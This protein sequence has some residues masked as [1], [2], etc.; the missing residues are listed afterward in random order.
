MSVHV[1]MVAEKPILAE[2]IA[3]IL[4]GGSCETRKGSNGACSIS[5][6]KGRFNNLSA[7]FKVTS[8]CGHVMGV[9]FPGKFNAW[10]RTD[11]AELFT[12]PIEHIEANPKLRMPA[13]LASVA[14]GCDYLVLWLDCDKEGENICFEV[15]DA[16]Q[17]SMKPSRSNNFLNVV[18]RARFSA[19]TEKEI[20]DAMRN[21]VRPNLNESLSVDARQELD[22]R[23]GCA[24]TRFQTKFFQEKYGDLDSNLIS[25]GPCQTPTLAF[26]VV[27]HDEIVNFKPQPYWLLQ[28]EIELPGGGRTLKLEW[29]RDRQFDKNAAQSFL[30]KIK[31]A[32]HATVVEISDKEHKKEKPVALNTVELLKVASSY[33]GLGPS[34]AMSVAEFLYTRGYTSY[35]RTETTAYPESFDFTSI[36]KQIAIIPE[37]AA[38]ALKIMQNGISKPRAGVNKGDHPPITPLKAKDSW[39][40]GDHL[41]IYEYIV[42]HFL[43]TL[44]PSC[45]YLTKTIK[46][47]IGEEQF[48]THS[49]VVTEPGFTELLTWMAV[50]QDETFD[51]IKKGQNFEIKEV[52]MVERVTTPPEYLTESELI[53]LME[54]YGIGT[55]ASIP[56]HINNICTRNYVKIET[57]RKLVP[58]KLGIALVHGYQKIDADLVEPTMRANVEKQLNL[59]AEG[60]ADYIAMKSQTLD[61]FKQKYEYFVTNIKLVDSFFEDSFKTLVES[62]KPFSK[63]GKC[64]RY[65]KLVEAKP[66]RLYCPTCQE[67]YP[68]PS[69][70]DASVRLHGEHLCP[71]DGFEILYFHPAGGKLAKSFA[72]CPHCY[73]NPPF[74]DMRG[75]HPGC[76]EC[77]HPECQHSYITQ[78]VLQC[79]TRCFGGRGTLVL[80]P[81]SGPKWRLSCNKC[82]AVV[83]I[84]EGAAKLKVMDRCEKCGARKLSVEYKNAKTSKLPDQACNF[85]GCAFCEQHNLGECVNFRHAFL[86]KEP[87]IGGS[88]GTRG[89]R[90]GR[91]RGR[92][93]TTTRSNSSNRD[94]VSSGRG[95]VRG[96]GTRGQSRGTSRGRGIRGGRGN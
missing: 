96:R 30:K 67:Q 49:R 40:S 86:D 60:K 75:R 62:G 66:Q 4:S 58:T 79:L 47:S 12:C 51:Q 43:A 72:F 37:F 22:L 8:T 6:Y 7:I 41:R 85:V 1:L 94:N 59:I 81:Q 16:V 92:G 84:F 55:D 57:G 9:D 3:R 5:T 53:S 2:S 52:K 17:N 45:K 46:F 93:S 65:M 83:S 23:I 82:P 15:I 70:K 50:S 61:M 31:N 73:N 74:E 44:M 26:C 76:N 68:V 34:S 11:P 27:R 20:K 48:L 69:A 28:A 56:T 29:A 33:L 38:F 42:Q 36:L 39:L 14:K 54:K 95:G 89:S 77:S 88:R 13:F 19:V 78:G 24:F 80:D 71:I 35:P 18:Y 64:R 21:L 10:H 32:K 91:G 90:G 87:N 63:C 25:F